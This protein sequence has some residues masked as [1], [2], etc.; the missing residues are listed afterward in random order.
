M[1][2]IKNYATSALICAYSLSLSGSESQ[3]K[4]ESY[5]V[6]SMQGHRPT[7]E[8]RHIAMPSIEDNEIFSFYGVYDGHGGTEASNFCAEHLHTNIIEELNKGGGLISD[9][10]IKGFEKTDEAFIKKAT[11][12]NIHSG[13][14]AVVALMN[15]DLLMVANLGDSRAVLCRN[16]CAVPLSIDHKPKREDEEERIKAAGG[17]ITRCDGAW[18]VGGILALSRAIGDTH[19]KR[20]VTLEDWVSGVPEIKKHLRSELDQFLILACDGV[21]DV[22]T[23][24]AAVYTVKK[25]LLEKQG[26]FTYAAEELRDEAFRR[27]SWDNISVVVINLKAHQTANEE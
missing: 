9:T 18:R 11:D 12:E 22:M 5:G 23:D 24:Q 27:R 13:S 17:Y 8:D 7:M 3:L 6:A 25:A 20:P 15:K 4:A 21:W 14:T 2:R 26:D 16:G 10:F 19:L 1:F